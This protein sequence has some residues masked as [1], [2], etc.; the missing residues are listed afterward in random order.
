MKVVLHEDSGRYSAYY[1]S[2][3][4]KSRYEPLLFERDPRTSSVNVYIDGRLYRMGESTDFRIG[5]RKNGSGAD[6]VFKSAACTVTENFSFMKSKGASLSDGIRITVT[7]D[8][9]TERDLSVGAR[10]IID[11]YLGESIT[12][13]FST[14]LRPRISTETRMDIRTRDE[15]IYSAPS[16]SGKV[17][18]L[19]PLP[20]SGLTQ[21]DAVT[22]ANWSRLNSSPWDFEFSAS[23]NFTLQ[24]YSIND[25]AISLDW[26]PAMLQAAKSKSFSFIIAGSLDS[27]ALAFSSKAG[28]SGP[29]FASSAENV[30]STGEAAPASGGTLTVKT[31]ADAKKERYAKAQTDFMVLNDLIERIDALLASGVSP[32]DSDLAELRAA[33]KE[34]EANKSRY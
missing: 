18:L 28:A 5:S 33:L 2:D 15:W 12:S 19:L 27:G 34:L 13:H 6:F 9:S 24:P 29:A 3:V 8:N 20:S 26:N 16:G 14:N 1:L 31:D 11:S 4:A 32:T 21:A 23:R 25:S 17:G 22:V 10:I 7:V 30:P